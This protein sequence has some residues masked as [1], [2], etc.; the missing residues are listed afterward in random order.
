M[1]KAPLYCYFFLIVVLSFLLLIDKTQAENVYTIMGIVSNEEGDPIEGATVL[2]DDF[3]AVTDSGGTFRFDGLPGGFYELTA[4]AHGYITTTEEIHIDDEVPVNI[5]VA[6][7]MVLAECPD[8][9][10]AKATSLTAPL[11]EITLPKNDSTEIVITVTD[12]TGCPVEGVKCKRL[13][14][15]SNNRYIDVT[16]RSGKSDEDGQVI[17]TITAKEEKESTK[18]KFKTKGLEDALTVIV[19]V[20][21]Q[22]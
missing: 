19:T 22:G 20:V 15:S 3:E 21:K 1:K 11:S 4:S 8:M 9:L 7:T 10:E 6:I 12:D 14:S 17:F 5:T 2:A 16:P 13:L 18:V